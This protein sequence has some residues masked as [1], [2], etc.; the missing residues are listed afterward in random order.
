LALPNE[1]VLAADALGCISW[2]IAID[3]R[4]KSYRVAAAKAITPNTNH[5]K[6]DIVSQSL[7]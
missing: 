4:E 6:I 5:L 7:V 1:Y 2:V 3:P